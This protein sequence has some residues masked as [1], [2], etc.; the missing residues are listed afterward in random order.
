MATGAASQRGHSNP[1]GTASVARKRHRERGEHG[2]LSRQP[3]E[4]S[5]PVP[6]RTRPACDRDRT[7]RPASPIIAARQRLVHDLRQVV[8]LRWPDPRRALMP[9]CR[10]V[11]FQRRADS[12][13]CTLSASTAST[14]QRQSALARLRAAAGTVR[15]APDQ[16][17]KAEGDPDLHEPCGPWGYGAAQ[18][19]QLSPPA[20]PG[21]NR[22]S[23]IM[24]RMPAMDRTSTPSPGI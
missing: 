18:Q 10:A 19:G 15:R 5:R 12:T 20:R 2:D 9:S 16:R 21:A 8:F 1:P 14:S 23:R 7:A 11:S 13:V 22:A 24:S 17:E 6:R 3:L 4:R